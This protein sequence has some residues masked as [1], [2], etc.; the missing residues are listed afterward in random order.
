MNHHEFTPPPQEVTISSVGAYRDGRVGSVSAL[1]TD[2]E[3]VV[4]GV[5]VMTRAWL[6]YLAIE[7]PDDT[8]TLLDEDVEPVFVVPGSTIEPTAIEDV[9]GSM[10]PGMLSHYLVEQGEGDTE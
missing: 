2:A 3:G 4:F 9:I 1:V 5:N 8:L 7:E 6:A 10:D